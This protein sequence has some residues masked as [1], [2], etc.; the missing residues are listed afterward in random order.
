MVLDTSQNLKARV[1]QMNGLRGT[2]DNANSVE[3]FV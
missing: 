3:P 2:E 1:E